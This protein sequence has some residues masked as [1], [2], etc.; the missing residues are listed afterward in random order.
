MR[1]NIFAVLGWT[2]MLFKTIYF[3][4]P[5]TYWESKLL[6]SFPLP[7]SSPSWFWCSEFM[8]LYLVATALY[9]IELPQ[10]LSGGIRLKCSSRRRWKFNP[11]VRKFPWSGTWQLNPVFS[12]VQSLSRVRICNLRNRSTPGLPVHHQLPEFTQTHVHRVSDAIQPSH[13]LSSP[14][15]PVLN[16]SQHQGYFKWVSSSHQV[17]KV[18]EFQLQHQS[19]QWTPRTDLL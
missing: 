12:S 7:S 19:F 4:E 3:Q 13:P 6:T 11:W 14:S 16:L 17:V 1:W 18:L 5:E 8:D 15:P 9:Y 10:W 2:A